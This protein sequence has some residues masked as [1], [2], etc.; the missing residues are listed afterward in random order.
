MKTL[1]DTYIISHNNLGTTDRE[2]RVVVGA[3]MI[4]AV[5]LYSPTSIAV[6]P[7]LA[8]I[9]IPFVITGLIGWDPF[10]GLLGINTDKQHDEDIHQRNWAF[11]NVGM[12][13]RV[14]RFIGGSALIGL[15]LSGE[16]VGWELMASLAA[17]PVIISAIIAWDPFYALTNSNTFA[18]RH[19][20][21]MAN[22]ELRKETLAQLY[23]FP[24][25][26]LRDTGARHGKAA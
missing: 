25:K 19:D 1:K 8:L 23:D 13:D 5:M 26:A 9:A 22:T 15:T 14:F 7:V 24:A 18:S 16:L 2:I 4:A 10:Y 6:W 17:V 3:S 20:V 12:L 21:E 11:S